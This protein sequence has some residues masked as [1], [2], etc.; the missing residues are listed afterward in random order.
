MSLEGVGEIKSETP[1]PPPRSFL[2]AATGRRSYFLS[3]EPLVPPAV[4]S[5]SWAV[6]VLAGR[7][8][9]GIRDAGCLPLRLS[10]LT[11][12]VCLPFSLVER[13]VILVSPPWGLNKMVLGRSQEEVCGK[14][15]A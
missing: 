7:V 3:G 6:P 14:F 5:P 11:P 13:E 8:V 12:L 15:L 9:G 2:L 1:P 10:A 4:G